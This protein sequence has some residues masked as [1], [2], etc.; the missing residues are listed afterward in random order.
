MPHVEIGAG[1][2]CVWLRRKSAQVL[3]ERC[4]ARS[5]SSALRISHTVEAATLIARL[6]SLS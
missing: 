4:G 2:A 6:A 3:V 5:M 1:W